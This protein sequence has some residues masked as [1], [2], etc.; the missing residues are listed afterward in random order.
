MSL[1]AGSVTAIVTCHANEQGLRNMLGILRYQTRPPD[2]ILVYVSG[3]SAAVF[4]R[5][6]EDFP[7]VHF[8]LVDDMEDWGH[9]KRATGL[10]DA[11]SEWVGFFNDDDSYSRDYLEKMLTAG[12]GYDVVFCAWNEIP[13]CE[14]RGCSSTAGNFLVRTSLARQAGWEGR[15]YAADAHFID[16]LNVAG[17]VSVKVPEILYRHN[18]Q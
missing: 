16:A 2:E 6:T 12:E 18:E 15:D 11:T 13:D 14:F 9:D 7:D 8:S 4:A 1:D 3:V 10:R 5:L 17:A